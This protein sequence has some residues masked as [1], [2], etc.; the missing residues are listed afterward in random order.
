MQTEHKQ[1]T[2]I[3]PRALILGVLLVLAN[4]YWLVVTNEIWYGLHMTLASLFFNAVFTLFAL[5]CINIVLQKYT[6]AIALS[7]QELLVI[8]VMVVMASTIAEYALVAE[9]MGNL[10]YPFW[11]ATPENEYAGLFHGHIPSWITVRDMDVLRGY[12][13]GDSSFYWRENLLPWLLPFAAWGSFIFVLW[14]VLISFNVLIRKQWTEREKLSYPIIQLPLKVTEPGMRIF[15]NKAMWIGFAIAGGIDLLNGLHFLFPSIPE[16]PIR[17]TQIQRY[18]AERP[19]NAIGYTTV[20][21][22]PFVIGLT[23]FV[24]LDLAFSCWFFHFLSKVEA[25]V[26]SA[27]GWKFL[28]GAPYINEQAA[29]A[30]LMIGAIAIFSLRR[31]LAGVLRIVFRKGSKE[32]LSEPMRYRTALLGMVVGLIYL[33]VF[34]YQA[35]M[36]LGVISAFFLIYLIM[37]I[38]IARVRAEVGPPVHGMVY[39]NPRQILVASFGTRFLGVANLTNLSFLYA[40]N[41]CN[42]MHPMP[43]Q[44]EAFKIA[45]RAGIKG[46][47]FVPAMLIAIIVGIIASFWISNALLYKRGAS[48]GSSGF[49]PSLGRESFHQLGNWLNYPKGTN[50]PAVSFMGGAAI[51]VV[52]LTIMR[53]RFIGWPFHPA[54]YALGNNTW[55]GIVYIWFAVFVGWLIKWIILRYGGLGS[56]RRAV[57]FFIGLILGEYIIACL[58]CILGIVLNI[59]VIRV[60]V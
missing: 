49:V 59:N 33:F 4:V 27:I 55:G 57:P 2:S 48:I 6:P 9:L 46:K 36:S 51:I 43:N 10:S 19:W 29:G 26:F 34:C 23:Y 22:Y 38:G 42:R 28:P 16:I 7:R 54:G 25:V 41:R 40:F 53:R 15:R 17:R 20:S 35:G 13:L 12:F 8:Y 3:R 50:V 31:H 58:W 18:F 52:F 30:W 5:V 44:L 47:R 39:V 21:F 37:A 14:F 24:P 56:Y 1:P 45:E 32:D 60:W 11:F